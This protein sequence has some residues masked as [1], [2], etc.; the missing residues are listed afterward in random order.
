M[1]SLA[2]FLHL[3]PAEGAWRVVIVDGADEMNRNAANAVLKILEEPPPKALL[4]LVATIPAGC[5]RPSAR[6]AAC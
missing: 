3:T 1:R 6:A 5:C 4:L 2:E